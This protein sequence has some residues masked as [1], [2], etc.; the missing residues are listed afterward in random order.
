MDSV[1][2]YQFNLLREGFNQRQKFELDRSKYIAYWV[3]KMAG[4]VV[5]D[6]VGLQD[7]IDPPENEGQDLE[8]YIKERFTPE[9]MEQYD[10]LFNPGKH[11]G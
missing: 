11:G 3:Y 8:S 2:P 9:K 10:K 1:T 4:K 6:P 7:F 5:E